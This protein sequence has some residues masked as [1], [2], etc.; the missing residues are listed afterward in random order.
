MRGALPRLRDD[1]PIHFSGFTAVLECLRVPIQAV[2]E[3]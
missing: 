3:P 1:H 2:E